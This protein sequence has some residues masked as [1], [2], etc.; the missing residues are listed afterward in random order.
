MEGKKRPI[1]IALIGLITILAA[2]LI[3]LA[4]AAALFSDYIID[5]TGI[6]IGDYIGYGGFIIGIITLIIGIAIWRGWT[7]AWYIAVIL[8]ALGVLSSIVSIVL[9]FTDEA[10]TQ[11]AVVPL[12]LPLVIG[13][14]IL[15]YLFRPKVKEFFGV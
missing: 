13:L 2:V 15:Y 5:F 6:D 9:V 3:L 10:A 12:L 4:A 14:L 1:L 11:A 7:I 8:Y